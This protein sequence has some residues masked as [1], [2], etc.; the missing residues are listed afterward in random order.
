LRNLTISFPG[1]IDAST[2]SFVCA[3][4]K[5]QQSI[6]QKASAI[7]HVLQEH[8]EI[9]V[10]MSGIKT[11]GEIPTRETTHSFL[12]ITVEKMVGL[13]PNPAQDS[14][15]IEEPLE[16]QLGY[17]PMNARAMKSISVT[18]RT[19]GDDFELAVGFL[20][21]EGVVRDAAEIEQI[22]YPAMGGIDVSQEGTN[23][24]GKEPKSVLP[25]QPRNNVVRVDLAPDVEVSLANLE[26][27]FYTTSSC[28]ICGKASL[29]ALRSVC[30]PR[31][32]SSFSIG[33]ELL[34]T[35][36]DR[37]REAQ[38][39]F[40]RTGG[41]HGAGLFDSAGMLLMLREDVGRHNAV[42]K[43][44]GAQFLADRT[45]LRDT[46]LLL[47]GRASFELLQKALMGGIPM[48]ASVGAPSSLAVQVAR[49]FNIVLVGFLRGN[50]FNI[51]HG[52]DRIHGHISNFDE[53]VKREATH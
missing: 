23:E 27:N 38:S 16:I 11:K 1:C 47:S 34:Y 7:Q 26:R 29:L 46:L 39:V 36:P 28:G 2:I 5:M 10:P 8:E 24:T 35:L 17:G 31:R 30:P 40:D 25:Y 20:M 14:V 51:Y 49:E 3:S 6:W 48:V 18:M 32:S 44:L 42:D 33:A 50:R 53:R 52:A 45:P 12:N 13:T 21:T 22:V 19:P 37:L 15:A 4:Q 9:A 43:L 41:L